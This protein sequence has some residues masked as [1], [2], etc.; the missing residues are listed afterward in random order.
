MKGN[1]VL[2]IEEK[3]DDSNPK[4]ENLNKW[5]ENII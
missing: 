2:K 5:I 4:I 3:L 1:G